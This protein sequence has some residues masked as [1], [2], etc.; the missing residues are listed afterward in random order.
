VSCL[1]SVFI[2]SVA[3]ALALAT[4]LF[5]GYAFAALRFPAKRLLFL[6]ILIVLIIPDEVILVPHYVVLDDLGWLKTYQAQII[7][8]AASA[9][10]IFFLRQFFLGLPR[11]LWDAAQIDGCTRTRFL[12]QVAAPLARPALTAVALYTFLGMWNQFLYPLVIAGLDPNVQ[13]I[14]V[15][16]SVFLGSHSVEW[17][18]LAAIHQ[19]HPPALSQT[20]AFAVASYVDEG[21][22]QDLTPY[23]YGRNGLTLSQRRDY[24]APQWQNGMYR[25]RMYSMPFGDNIFMFKD[26]SP[27]VK[28]A[29]WTYMKWA[30]QPNWTAWWSEQLDASPVR[31]S[32][33]G[34]M[35]AF[36]KSHPLAAVPITELNRAYY[37]PTVSG[38]AEAQGDIDTEM[39][40]AMLGQETAAQAMQRATVKVYHDIATAP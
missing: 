2:S 33:V 20:D 28:Q 25:G 27:A 16:L 3:T 9:F 32:A 38:W 35:R 34:L 39:S 40:N 14:Q 31:R 23:I 19:H 37:S 26:A 36:L 7:P 6:G 1:N 30:T 18:Q 4:S 8:F 15:G 11:E 10:G 21:A 29:A 5:A 12:L 13:P 24:F 17:S 22:V